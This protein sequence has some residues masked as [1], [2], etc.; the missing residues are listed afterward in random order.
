MND[1]PANRP[2]PDALLAE[3]QKHESENRRGRLKIFFGMCAGVGKTYA[4]LQEARSLKAEG[5]DVVVGYVETHKRS[6]TDAL[7]E[8]LEIIPRKSMLH[9]GLSIE[10]F[11]IDAVLKRH[12]DLVLV[13][14]LAHTNAP[15]SRH[16]KRYQDIEEL[17]DRGVNVYTTLNVQHL[18]SRAATVQEITQIKIRETVPD[19]FLE[20]AGDIE[21]VDIS[22]SELL[23]RFAEG[24]I[25]APEGARQALRNF[26]RHGNLTALR[27]MSLRVTA[28]QVDQD[29]RD[30]M[31]NKK[32][33]GPWKSGERLMVAVSWSPFSAQLIRWTRRMADTMNAT[34][35]AVYVETGIQLKTAQTARLT[36]NLRLAQ[37][38]GA[39]IVTVPSSDT[40]QGLLK[41]ARQRN[42]TQIVVGKPM[43]S[44][45]TAWIRGG[46]M[47]DK[48]I[49]SSGNIDIY[50][51]RNDETQ[52]LNRRDWSFTR[53]TGG[54]QYGKAFTVI[55]GV[56]ALLFVLG[57]VLDYLAV[58][59]FL[60][61]T[62][63]LLSLWLGRGPVLFSAAISAL[64]WN[65]LFIPPIFTFHVDRLEDFLIVC[66]YFLIAMV[67]GT[68]TYRLR[69]K[70][71]AVRLREERA[72][73]LYAISR[74]LASAESIDAI[75][76]IAVEQIGRVFD[77]D[78]A[79][80]LLKNK[81]PMLHPASGFLVS[82]KELSVV[83]WVAEN[84]KPAGRFTNSLPLAEAHYEPLATTRDRYG[85]IA[86][87]FRGM[88][89]F[90][91]DQETL[92][93]NFL[94]QIA[95]A[96]ERERFN[97]QRRRAEM[98]EASE[99]LYK[100]LLNSISHEFKTPLAVIGGAA[101]TLLDRDIKLPSSSRKALLSE[102]KDAS[103]RLNELVENLLNMS[104]L[105][106]GRIR[107]K[108]E[109]C[110]LADLFSALQ[111]RFVTDSGER[112]VVFDLKPGQPLVLIDSGLVEQTVGNLI[113]NGLQHT[114]DKTTVRVQASVSESELSVMVMDN[115]AGLPLES[116]SRLFD[117]FYRAPGTASGGTGL[118]LSI[119][120][121]FAESMNG[122]LT[123][124]NLESGGAMFT[125]RLPVKTQ[126]AHLE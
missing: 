56:V 31:Q 8:G 36:D 6:E 75:V 17:L 5:R 86:V 98:D 32:I 54:A 91:L 42:I 68:L 9:R 2:D 53:L 49:R 34:W 101:G 69:R 23:K 7:L 27:E 57:P 90:T 117:K 84:R 14:E 100:T 74:A 37:E 59:I 89:I 52:Q 88:T 29:L 81:H 38:L 30:Y 102:V 63:T 19:S 21:L 61:F 40:I 120:K 126:A 35:I 95:A 60:L 16:P 13:D 116:L 22:P 4:M 111:R 15:E 72:V 20:L 110:D 65:F 123:A 11:D 45:L 99:Q 118:G 1:K 58:G 96:V 51:V 108:L 24:K 78:V 119:S 97:E 48:L 107:P 10:E 124:A 125:L 115:G 79:V 67:T 80:F 73:A 122:T 33:D 105:E 46:S 93:E 39:E 109:W 77:A 50:V 106:S 71:E 103:N 121:G 104:R 43:Q 12:P 41:T 18:E 66:L 85:V 55:S 94:S 3:I 76:A 92:L 25:Y 44:R 62:V 28:Q 47:V 26:F 113:Q 83:H 112:S 82:E 114:P 87:H 64:L 70:E